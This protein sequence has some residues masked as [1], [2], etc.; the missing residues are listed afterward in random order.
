MTAETTIADQVVK[1]GEIATDL[2]TIAVSHLDETARR[3]T[4]I[5][6]L[7]ADRDRIKAEY[8]AHMRTHAPPLPTEIP[9]WS[10]DVRDAYGT[11][12]VLHL[13]EA[14]PLTDWFPILAASGIKHLRS[15]FVPHLAAQLY[16]LCRDAG[17]KWWCPTV[18]EGW[19]EGANWQ[20]F[21]PQVRERVRQAVA[22]DRQ[23]R[24]AGNPVILGFGGPNEPNNLRS[25]G[26]VPTNWPVRTKEFLAAIADELTKAGVRDVYAVGNAALHDVALQ[27]SRGAHDAALANEGVGAIIDLHDRH[28]YQ[29]NENF[30]FRLEESIRFLDAAYVPSQRKPVIISECGYVNWDG[31][32]AGPPAVDERTSSIYGGNFPLEAFL[33]PRV[34][35]AYRFKLLDGVRTS[36]ENQKQTERG[37]VEGPPG[38]IPKREYLVLQTLLNRL[39]DT[40]PRHTP[41]PVPFELVY[42]SPDLRYVLSQHSSGE[43]WVDMWLS[44][45]LPATPVQV[46]VHTASGNSVHEVGAGH[47]SVRVQ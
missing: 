1:L 37:I 23:A 26:P 34:E 10:E 47:V 40:G 44:V 22:L 6:D 41:T 38:R 2:N 18:P 35:R 42:D 8:E 14:E 43:T 20:T 17:V 28:R 4:A 9:V 13:P 24:E 25:G 11:N 29:N 21:L 31:G 32:I 27:N 46:T 30:H 19:L 45:N 39:K 5:A 16:G 15:M 36:L 3:D 33:H 12:V 7:T